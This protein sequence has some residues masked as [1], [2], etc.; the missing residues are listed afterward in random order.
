ML[1]SERGVEVAVNIEFSDD[2]AVRENRNH[3]FRFCFQRTG[4]VSRIFIDIVD[5]DRLPAGSR[6]TADS[7]V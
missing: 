5:D 2:F 3:Y 7:L 4:Q 1:R 6:C